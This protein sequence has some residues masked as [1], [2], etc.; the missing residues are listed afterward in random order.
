MYPAAPAF[1]S[2]QVRP[3]DSGE[4][5]RASSAMAGGGAEAGGEAG[6]VQ[7]PTTRPNQTTAVPARRVIVLMV[8]KVPRPREAA[9]APMG[10]LTEDVQLGDA[11]PSTA[12]A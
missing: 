4:R 8:P 12:R 9:E 3:I 1:G 2:F 11:V 10:L 6:L 5:S 7:P